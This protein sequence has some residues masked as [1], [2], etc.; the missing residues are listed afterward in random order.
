[1]LLLLF[2]ICSFKFL[3]VIPHL[4]WGI[5]NVLQFQEYAVA[6]ANS[7][8]AGVYTALMLSQVLTLIKTISPAL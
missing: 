3:K 6:L 7:G 5:T 8:V 1:M 4:W 2:E